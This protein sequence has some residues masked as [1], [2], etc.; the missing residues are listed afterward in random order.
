MNTHNICFYGEIS[1]I[2]PKLLP[3]TLLICSTDY[4]TYH[5]GDQRMLRRA[6]ASTQTRQSLHCSHTGSMEEDEGSDKTSDIYQHLMA[7]HAHLQNEF[8]KDEKYHN[9]MTLLN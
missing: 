7:A 4:G 6:C 8:T 2:I 3:N 5:I 9:L 1:I